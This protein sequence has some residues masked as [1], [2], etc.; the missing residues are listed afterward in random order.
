[1]N[2]RCLIIVVAL[3]SAA[4]LAPV[5]APVAVQA[6]DHEGM[7]CRMGQDESGEPDRRDEIPRLHQA[8]HVGY[9]RRAGPCGASDC[10]TGNGCAG[11]RRRSGNTRCKARDRLAG[12]PS[13]DRPRARLRRGVEGR[14]GRGQDPGRPEMA[15]VLSECDKRKKAQ[16]M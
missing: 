16:G 1:M 6:E 13:H 2:S 4:A 10:S 12:P 3:A 11:A 9:R 5:V 8:M 14:Q 15:A 7:R